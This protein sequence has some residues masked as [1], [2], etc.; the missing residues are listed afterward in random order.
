MSDFGIR[1]TFVADTNSGWNKFIATDLTEV[2]LQYRDGQKSA[3]FSNGKN[4]KQCQI[5][6]RALHLLQAK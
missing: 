2:F 4:L 1:L 5:S 6:E 3:S